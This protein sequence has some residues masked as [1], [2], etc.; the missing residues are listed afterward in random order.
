MDNK[1][2]EIISEKTEDFNEQERM[3]AKAEKLLSDTFT[4]INIKEYKDSI[5]KER[6]GH[7]KG[8]K[9]KLESKI[10]FTLQ[11]LDENSREVLLRSIL[12]IIEDSSIAM[13]SLRHM[14]DDLKRA[15]V[16][17]IEGFREKQ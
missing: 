9:A 12:Q 16:E 7:R 6:D 4:N 3:K 13:A 11:K 2:I 10:E 8:V 17:T 14:P 5:D 15:V 1:K